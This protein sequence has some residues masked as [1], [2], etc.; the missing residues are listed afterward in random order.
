[1]LL[2][3]AV[4]LSGKGETKRD[5]G[6]WTTFSFLPGAPCYLAQKG[7]KGCCVGSEVAQL[8]PTPCD[9]MDGSLPG[10]SIHRIFQA[11]VRGS[12]TLN[13]KE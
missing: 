10:F 6:D 9:P 4:C 2:G 5:T 1:M 7:Y 3:Q 13:R 8:S 12:E 11:R